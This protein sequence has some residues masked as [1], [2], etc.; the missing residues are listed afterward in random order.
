MLSMW[1]LERALILWRRNVVGARGRVRLGYTQP[2]P[3]RVPLC[4]TWVL[5]TPHNPGDSTG[6][7]PLRCQPPVIRGGHQTP[8]SDG[9]TQSPPPIYMNNLWIFMNDFQGSEVWKPKWSRL[10]LQKVTRTISHQQHC[11]RRCF[12]EVALVP[13]VSPFPGPFS[14]WLEGRGMIIENSRAAGRSDLIFA[15]SKKVY[16]SAA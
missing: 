7:S 12:G 9:K 16:P 10:K 15:K 4:S 8:C 3:W 11:S 6:H 1:L 2:S 13:E 14:C 5:I